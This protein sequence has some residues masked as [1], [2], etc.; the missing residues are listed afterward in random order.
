MPG[1]KSVLISLLAVSFLF[2]TCTRHESPAAPPTSANPSPVA[3]AGAPSSA[4]VSFLEGSATISTGTDAKPAEIGC[5]VPLS[6]R[7]ATAAESHCDIALGTLG[8]IRLMP[9]TVL[10]LSRFDLGEG[11][12]IGIVSL[13]EGAVAA[14]VSRLAATDRFAVT[15]RYSVLGV[16]GTEFLVSFGKDGPLRLAVRSGEVAVL[17]RT[18]DPVALGGS[19]AADAVYRAILTEAPAVDAG[20]E[21]T[22]SS[23]A[24]DEENSAWAALSPSVDAA[25]VQAGA[26]VQTDTLLLSP[27]IRAAL[28]GIDTASS[29]LSAAVKPADS[30]TLKDFKELDTMA[31][32]GGTHAL[33]SAPAPIP[34]PTTSPSSPPAP[35]A[36]VVPS[37]SSRL[38]AQANRPV[39]IALV[40]AAWSKEGNQNLVVASFQPEKL[41]FEQSS[42]SREE[43]ELDLVAAL[44]GGA[45]FANIRSIGARLGFAEGAE[46]PFAHIAINLRSEEENGQYWIE[47]DLIWQIQRLF[48]LC[49]AGFSGK[50]GNKDD[51]DF[52]YEGDL[53]L[54]RAYDLRVDLEPASGKLVWYLDGAQIAAATAPG[55]TQR[56]GRPA[57]IILNTYRAQSS[58]ATTFAERVTCATAR[59]N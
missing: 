44:P 1:K 53:S 36:S 11:R 57:K 30:V 43:G 48:I 25:I 9:L 46:G 56:A 20:N 38:S 6:S 49:R 33:P 13:V 37:T 16:R 10:E 41:S 19:T 34:A 5:P 35:A 17:P 58:F 50:D 31:A 12:R 42:P 51:F 18:L 21:A 22:V 23:H 52:N 4:C 29:T 45:T 24:L 59:T 39:D 32:P 3:A 15:T 40:E 26:A 54:G 55:L 8:V 14:K 2:A 47:E 27:S 28:A 7:V